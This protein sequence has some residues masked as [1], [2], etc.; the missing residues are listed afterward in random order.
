MATIRGKLAREVREYHEACLTLARMEEALPAEVLDAEVGEGVVVDATGWSTDITLRTW[1]PEQRPVPGF[2]SQFLQFSQEN[3]LRLERQGSSDR[4]SLTLGRIHNEFAHKDQDLTVTFSFA[5]PGCKTYR[6]QRK[7]EVIT[8]CG[9]PD[10]EHY[11][12]IEEVS[13]GTV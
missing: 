12:V 7:P 3:E 2:L 11:A 1:T 10:R 8:V 4:G 13:D 9:E 5:A 6:V